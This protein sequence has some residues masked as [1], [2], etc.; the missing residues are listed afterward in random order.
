MLC[1]HAAARIVRVDAAAVTRLPGVLG[2]YA[3]GDLTGVAM[4]QLL[5]LARGRAVFAGQP[6]AVV[7]AETEA[8]AADAAALL[9][10]EYE[11]LPA[12]VDARAAL[13]PGAPA[14]YEGRPNQTD[15]GLMELGDAAACLAACA[16]VVGGSYHLPAIH[17]A[18]LEPH[19]VVARHRSDGFT[20]WTPTQSLFVTQ[21]LTAAALGVVS[22]AVRVVPTVV[23]GGFGGKLA[24]VLEPL[25]AWLARELRRPVRLVLTRTE[26]FLFA[27]RAT[28][29]DVDLRLGADAEGRLQ[30]L[31]ATVVVDNGAGPGFPAS[32]VGEFLTRPYSLAAYRV[33]CVGAMTNTPPANAYRGQP[34]ALACFALESAVDELALRL[35]AYPVDLRLRN[36]R[37]EGEPDPSGGTWPRVGG[38]EC[39]EAARPLLAELGPE[40]GLAYGVWDGYE[41]AAAAGCRLNPDGS[42]TVQVGT[43]DISGTHTALAMLAADAFGLPLERVSVELGD[44]GSAPRGPAAGGS[45]V[46]YVLGGA[47]A[48]AAA[49]ARRQLLEV[50]AAVLEAAVED[51]ELAE[52]RVSVRG[53]PQRSRTV[54]EL[55]ATIYGSHSR[56]APV[57]GHSRLQVGSPSPMAAVH[58]ARVVADRDTGEWRLSG[59]ATVQ[60][61]GRALNPAEVAA[62]VHGGAVQGIGRAFGEEMVRDAEGAATASFVTYEIP[63]ADVAPD[64]R[65]TLVEVPAAYGELGVRGV[66]EPP[67]IPGPPAIANALARSAGVRLRR[68]PLTAQDVWREAGRQRGALHS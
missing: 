68:L 58:V 18:P 2:A 19:V 52:G 21:Q 48:A 20:V 44:S 63:T 34:S 43:P 62:Q 26:E 10:V 46:T 24:V 13:A 1:P 7:V 32:R 23:G 47:V 3:G 51:L 9:E 11:P 16:V 64:I 8:Q 33:A 27:G 57:H 28:C 36:L 37:S 41:G 50:A 30:A 35:G 40:A 29:C 39:L 67:I 65:V 12:V 59:Y 61:V 14:V 4:P 55:A 60:D 38:R 6:V 25:V 66:G 42:L 53:V 15:Q 31:E 17:Q 5:L 54:N 45:A 22:T 56:H 49:D